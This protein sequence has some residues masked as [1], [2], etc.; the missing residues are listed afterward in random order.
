MNYAYIA[1]VVTL[2]AVLIADIYDIKQSLKGIQKG[3]GVE[4][5]SIIT[6]LA[7]TNKP[8]FFQ[9][10]WINLL[11]PILPLGVPG[12]ISLHN[13]G[14]SAFSATALSFGIYSHI[15]GGLDWQYLINGGD[16]NKL[17]P[18]WWQKIL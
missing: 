7:G 4:G 3:V 2:V 6:T 5:N 14:L 1:N 10:L 12:L 18:A 8:T 15:H 11:I 16:P 17:N 13:P 9:Y